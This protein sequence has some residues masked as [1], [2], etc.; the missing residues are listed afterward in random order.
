MKTFIDTSAFYALADE[1]DRYHL[2][3]RKVYEELIGK[4]E[5]FTTDYILLECWSLI[6][7]HLGRNAALKFWDF[8]LSGA[9]ELVMVE[10]KD[11]DRARRIIADFPDQDLSLVDAASFAVMERLGIKKAF[12][13]DQRFRI[14]RF[15]QGK[16]ERF[17]VIPLLSP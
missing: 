16:E 13:F 5:L 3:A 6:A 17:E 2:P 9:I 8:L 10:R 4:E 1:S 15:G 14:H 7:H 12:A 11:L